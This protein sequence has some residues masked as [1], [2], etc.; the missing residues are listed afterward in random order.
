[1]SEDTTVVSYTDTLSIG[2]NLFVGLRGHVNGNYG[3]YT[4]T[5]G[6]LILLP[7]NEIGIFHISM[8][9]L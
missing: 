8:E 2:R 3:G 7:N 1:M 4:V 5:Y 9:Y 6:F